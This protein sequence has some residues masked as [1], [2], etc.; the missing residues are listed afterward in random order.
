[1]TSLAALNA[2]GRDAFVAATG[3]A[4]EKSPWIAAR[5]WE[6]RPF[7]DLDALHAALIDVVRAA[8]QS[9]QVALIAA[10]PE[11]AAPAKRA[12]ELT[13][14]SRGEQR[15][16]GLDALSSEESER[17]ARANAAYRTRFG[18]PFVVCARRL[19]AAGIQRAL[20]RRLASD[21]KT[22]I[23]TALDEIAQIARL[24]LQ[25]AIT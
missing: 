25:D 17:F 1:M 19:D 5:A 18:F 4:F 9:E 24:R 6:R 16:A 10:H 3:F 23:A 15:S 7:A 14:E 21:R 22:E 8:P 12:V 20:E 13:P 11:L 2:A